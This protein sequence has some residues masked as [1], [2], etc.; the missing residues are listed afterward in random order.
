MEV[1]F[2]SSSTSSKG[3]SSESTANSVNCVTVSDTDVSLPPRMKADQDQLY[4]LKSVVKKIV[5]QDI[6][7]F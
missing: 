3:S 2:S 6:K 4:Y 5:L 7:C 1:S